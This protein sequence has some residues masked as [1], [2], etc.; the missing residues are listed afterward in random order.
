MIHVEE[1]DLIIFLTQNEEHLKERTLFH[2]IHK[3]NHKNIFP[4]SI[5][6]IH[7]FT[8]IVHEASVQQSLHRFSIIRWIVR[9]THKTEVTLKIRVPQSLKARI[10]NFTA[11]ITDSRYHHLHKSRSKD[12]STLETSYKILS[13]SSNR[14]AS[15][16]AYIQDPISG[17][18]TG[19]VLWWTEQ[20]SANAPKNRDSYADLQCIEDTIITG[21][22]TLSLERM[23]GALPSNS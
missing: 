6:Q 11:S 14:R 15:D 22:V 21:E 3:Q 17:Q 18:R 9:L 12:C 20:E 5:E 10:R 19:R 13:H 1:R 16:P 7:I 23:P 4:Y 2:Q 8:Q